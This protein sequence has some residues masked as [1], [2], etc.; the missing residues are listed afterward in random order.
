M[1]ARYQDGKIGRF[2]SQ[3][4][5]FLSV[6]NPQQLKDKTGLEL[7]QYLSD[8]QGLNSYSYARNNPLRLVDENG[9]WFKEFATGQQSWNSFQLELG[10]ASQQLS[11]DSARWNTAI[12]HPL[13]TGAV[14]G[15]GSGG[16]AFLG[17]GGVAALSIQYL[18]GA[19]T[20]CAAF[21]GKTPEITRITQNSIQMG[22]RVLNFSSHALKRMS[23]R[24]ISNEQLLNTFKNAK[25]F[26][27][28]HEGVMKTGYY[29]PASKV[30]AGE[31][32]GQ[33]VVT[34]VINNVKPQYIKNLK[35]TLQIINN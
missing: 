20:A 1:N 27:Y 7:E 34:T 6:G 26:D 11:Q 22:D 13:A 33:G 23:E 35:E 19:G 15:I 4:P 29:D 30:F 16:V 24:S 3:D 18:G 8:P 21:C 28:I 14:V 9:E 31:I 17:A 12:S 10:Q 5:V 25:P 2:L 32:K